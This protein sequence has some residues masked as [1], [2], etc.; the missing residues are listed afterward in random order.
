MEH[1]LNPRLAE[2]INGQTVLITGGTGSF[3]N[4]LTTVLLHKFTPKK[5]IIFSRDEYKQDLM[6]RKFTQ[7]EM[8][9]F[10]GDVRDYPR[11]KTAFKGVDLIFHA[12]ALKQVPAVEYNPDEA[13]KT[14]IIGSQNIIKAAIA[15][16]VKRVVAV[17]TDKSVEPV[18]L[19]GATKMCLERLFVAGNCMSGEDGPIFSV[20]RYGNVFGSRGSVVPLFL[21]QQTSGTLT[22]T[23]TRMTRFT[24]S[25]D[26]AI[27]FVLNCAARMIGG[28]IFVPKL[29]SYNIGQL[30][31]VLA[32]ECDVNIIGIRPGEKL[33]EAMIGSSEAYLAM[34]FDTFYVIQPFIRT[35][36]SQDYARAYVDQN[37]RT[38]EDGFT[39]TSGNNTLITDAAL[40]AVL[41]TYKAEHAT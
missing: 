33:H 34:E 26:A 4:Q 1:A 15:C 25:L 17:S 27:A 32:P 18:N 2:C 40:R 7:V 31:R 3:G 12:A 22:I 14:N 24:L 41:D 21:K 19:Y 28:E 8:R 23:D 9:F 6:R 10:L 29:P 20:L 11:L 5:V 16:D 13:V 37:P 36:A 38:V 39:Y 30:A 35:K